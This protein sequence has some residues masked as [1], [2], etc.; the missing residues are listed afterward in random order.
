MLATTTKLYPVVALLCL[1][2]S[3]LPARTSAVYFLGGQQVL[4]YKIISWW[5]FAAD[6]DSEQLCGESITYRSNGDVQIQISQNSSTM[7]I[8]FNREWAPLLA[9]AGRSDASIAFENVILTLA[10]ALIML[11]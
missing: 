5:Y 3:V 1:I 7:K 9:M 8:S 10:G 2:L 6:E 11:V 4:P